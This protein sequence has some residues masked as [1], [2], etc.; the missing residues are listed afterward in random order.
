MYQSHCGH[1]LWESQWGNWINCHVSVT[2]THYILWAAILQN[3]ISISALE[4]WQLLETYMFSFF[5]PCYFLTPPPASRPFSSCPLKGVVLWGSFFCGLPA[6]F[7]FTIPTKWLR[8]SHSCDS[9]HHTAL[10]FSLWVA[11]FT[12]SVCTHRLSPGSDI[13]VTVSSM[14]LARSQPCRNSP[15]SLSSSSETGSGGGT[16][17]QKSMPEG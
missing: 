13:Y 6:G 10:G 1:I 9:T 7:I 11:D 12:F 4:F 14:A 8:L 17:R 3:C 2:G 16:Y 15:S 5:P